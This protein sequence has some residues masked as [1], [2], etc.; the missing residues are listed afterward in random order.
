MTKP[1]GHEIKAEQ[2]ALLILVNWCRV[3]SIY[4]LFLWRRAW[5]PRDT[6]EVDGSQMRALDPPLAEVLVTTGDEAHV[7]IWVEFDAKDW[8]ITRVPVGN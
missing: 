8:K 1:V 2:N 3:R 6:D 5:R 7:I 4:L